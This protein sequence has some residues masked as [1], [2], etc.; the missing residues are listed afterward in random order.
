MTSP[1]DLDVATE[2]RASIRA[3]RLERLGELRQAGVEPYPYRFVRTSDIEPVRQEWSGLEA[4][5][6][7]GAVVRLAGRLM[8]KREQGRLTFGQLR[9]R[10]GEI[11]LF[12]SAGVLG[13]ESFAEFNQLDRG[14]WVGVEGE[15][16]ATKKGELS[17]KVAEWVLL[18]KALR[19]L[20]DKWHGLADVDARYR[21]RY[22][23]LTVNPDARRVFEIR[24]AAVDAIR[25]VLRERGYLEVETP[26]LNLQQGGATARP[27]VTHYNALD[28][29]TYLRIALELPLKRLLVGGLDRVFEIGRVFR[30]EGIDTRHNPEFTMLESYEAFADYNDMMELVESLVSAAAVA[31]NGSTTVELRGAQVDLAP[32]WRR[33]TMVELIKELVGVDIN[34]SMEIVDARAVLDGLGLEWKKDWGAGRC[35]HEVYDELVEPKVMEPTIVFDHPRETSPLAKPHRADPSLVERFEVIV[36]GRELANAYSELNDPVE[37]LA[38]FREEAAHKAA[39]DLEAGDVDLDYIRA[40][41]YGMP[42]AGG[43]GIGID[44]LVM[45][46]AAVESI[47]EVILFPTL[48]P[49]N[50]LTDADFPP[51]IDDK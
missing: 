29:D 48:R 8:L 35:T 45:I 36:D 19:P 23:D 43:L 20:P 9:D 1:E 39:G 21:Q 44:R 16:M 37:Q 31:A 22:V 4:G 10:S 41:E 42:P 34:P 11:Q 38:R 40:L 14:D 3:Q 24:F 17:I 18:S 30:N 51:T 32:P 12:V 28:I 49:E 27:F 26:V 6:E 2:E 47:R 50:S 7:T 15:I 25:Q 46:L 5:S 33:V 13:K